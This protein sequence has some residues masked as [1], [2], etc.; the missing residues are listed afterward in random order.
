M[1]EI[2][3]QRNA[4]RE[5]KKSEHYTKKQGLGLSKFLEIEKE[6]GFKPRTASVILETP[7]LKTNRKESDPRIRTYIKEKKRKS[8]EKK[9]DLII[10]NIKTETKRIA[11][12]KMLDVKNHDIIKKLKKKIKRIKKEKNNQQK[13]KFYTKI[14]DKK[15]DEIKGDEFFDSHH[16]ELK[17]E[18]EKGS[19]DFIFEPDSALQQNLSDFTEETEQLIEPGRDETQSARESLEEGKENSEKIQK[20]IQSIREKAAIL[21]Q[22]HIR[23][24]LARKV[25]L[26]LQE[27]FTREDNEVKNIL[28]S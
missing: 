12:L 8:I 23:R 18:E 4:R 21:I 16:Y 13:N 19:S 26:S 25:F 3:E 15:T 22:S 6:L 7:T 17:N 27:S 14:T 2:E 11:S 24:Y 9:N 1:K 5:E 28:S 20:N 10:E